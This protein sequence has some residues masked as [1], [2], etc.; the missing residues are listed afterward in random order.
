MTNE[1]GIQ[2]KNSTQGLRGQTEVDF[3]DATVDTVLNSIGIQNFDQITPYI[4]QAAVLN[5]FNVPYNVSK[6]IETALRK[7]DGTPFGARLFS[8]FRQAYNTKVCRVTSYGTV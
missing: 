6:V 5:E 1:F 8:S 2:I 4:N 3:A 7:K